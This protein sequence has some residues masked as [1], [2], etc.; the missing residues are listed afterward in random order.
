VELVRDDERRLT[1]DEGGRA[2]EMDAV[3]LVLHGGKRAPREGDEIVVALRVERL[4]VAVDGKVEALP[5]D[6][7][8]LLQLREE[9]APTRRRIRRGDEEPV[10]PA[11][12][13]A[14]RRRERVAPETVRLEPLSG[15]GISLASLRHRACAGET[16]SLSR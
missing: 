11:R 12:Q 15:K 6:E 9:D 2:D 3:D 5:V 10:I 14:A 4:A 1:G 7:E 8:A 13:E 16:T